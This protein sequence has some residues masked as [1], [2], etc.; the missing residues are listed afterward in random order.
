[1]MIEWSNFF[2]G[3]TQVAAL[4]HWKAPQLFIPADSAHKRWSHSAFYPAYRYSARLLRM[5]LRMWATSGLLMHTKR[6]RSKNWPLSAF[7]HDRLPDARSV[8]V[9]VGTPGP[10]QKITVQIRNPNDT[11]IGYLKYGQKKMAQQ[12]LRQEHQILSNLP[13]GLGPQPLKFGRWQ[14]GLALL[15]SPVEGSP[16]AGS[17]PPPSDLVPF[18][19]YSVHNSSFPIDQHPWVQRQA[20]SNTVK[21]LLEPLNGRS[22]PVVVQHGDLAPWNLRR[23][24]DGSLNAFDWEYGVMQGFPYLDVTY[25]ILQ[26]AALIYEWPPQKASDYALTYLTDHPFTDLSS[27]QARAVV[28]L[29]AYDGYRNAEEDGHTSD[30]SLQKWRHEIWN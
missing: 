26:V 5:A 20:P 24:K 18:C 27:T 23:R 15:I 28:R 19:H 17:L 13:A 7:I 9:L 16:L 21:Q 6:A 25:Y 11:V 8:S 12:R 4:P 3:N 22:W 30:R 14:Q 10:A 29:A 1:M 2:P